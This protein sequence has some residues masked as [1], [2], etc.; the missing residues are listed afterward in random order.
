MASASR[1][2]YIS[3][4]AILAILTAGA[5][6]VPVDADDPE[7]RAELE[8][9]EAGVRGVIAGAG[10]F[11]PSAVDLGERVDLAPA[12]V[13]T[14]GADAATGA[15]FEG[16][17]LNWTPDVGHFRISSAAHSSARRKGS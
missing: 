17:P 2:L 15:L 14:P 6:Y 3:I 13:P 5:A 4:L 9:R 7:E 10:R 1:E 11:T 12:P 16:R 8:F